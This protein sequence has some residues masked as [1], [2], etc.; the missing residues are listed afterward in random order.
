MKKR[1]KAVSPIISTVMLILI[2]IIL[3]IIIFLWSRSFIKESIEKQ[4]GDN[5]KR[6]D[7]LCSELSLKPVINGDEFGFENNGNIP[8]Y[9]YSV[10]SSS[11]GN[12][13]IKKVEYDEGGYAAPGTLVMVDVNLV[14]Y[15]N[16]EEIKILP[17]LLGEG[18]DGGTKEFQ[19]PERNAVVIK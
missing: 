3:A 1:N 13:D 7:E 6:V 16:S 19:C 8:I 12:S 15:Q 5:R 17:I 2:V 10:K 18:E 11:S 9:A 4:V 14:D